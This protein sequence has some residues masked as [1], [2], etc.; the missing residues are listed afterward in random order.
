V[1]PDLYMIDTGNNGYLFKVT[2]DNVGNAITVDTAATAS[3]AIP[4]ETK[5]TQ[6]A[7]EHVDVGR[8]HFVVLSPVNC[9][10]D[11]AAGSTITSASA[12]TYSF[13]T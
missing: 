4:A 7:P 9:E 2:Y 8:H 5:I 12:R 1:L 10:S 13:G 3:I 6:M 11:Q